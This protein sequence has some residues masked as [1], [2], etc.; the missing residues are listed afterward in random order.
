MKLIKELRET[1]NLSQ[2]ELAKLVGVSRTKIYDLENDKSKLKDEDMQRLVSIFSKNIELAYV[3]GLFDRGCSIQIVKI[4]PYKIHKS[5]ISPQYLASIKFRSK[6]EI[7]CQIVKETFGVGKVCNRETSD[8]PYYEYYVA[9]ENVDKVVD[10]LLPYCK[11]KRAKLL[12]MKEFRAF[13]EA[14]RDEWRANPTSKYRNIIY[15]TDAEWLTIKQMQE[16]L[17]LKSAILYRYAE[18][19]VLKAKKVSVAGSKNTQWR[20]CPIFNL[21]EVKETSIRSPYS[22]E[23]L[24]KYEEF[25]TRLKNV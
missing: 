1:S 8:R 18:S 15:Q 20:F 2:R 10:L 14:T 23:V 16:A 11:I 5:Q 21:N 12:V 7:L 6:F 22:Q 13:L 17:N 3:A 9:C 24:D 25:Y 4:A 19:G